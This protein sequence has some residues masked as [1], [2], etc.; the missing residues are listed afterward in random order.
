MNVKLFELRDHATFIP[1]IAIQVSGDDGWLAQRAGYGPYRMVLFSRLDGGGRLEYDPFA[2]GD[3]T[4]HVA[5]KYIQDNW[6]ELEDGDLI[7]VR[8]ILGETEKPCR[9][10]YDSGL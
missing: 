6:E 8:W 4:F 7:D 1:A 2:W 9:S 3:R 5:H 10:E